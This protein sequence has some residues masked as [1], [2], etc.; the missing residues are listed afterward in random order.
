MMP[1]AYDAAAF[2][3]FEAAE[4]DRSAPSYEAFAA[5]LTARTI[6]ALLEVA[7]VG[8]GTRVLDAAT[9]TGAVA[10]E[11][12]ALGANAVG[13]DVSPAMLEL[14]RSRHPDLE[15]VEASVYELPFDDGA[16]DAAVCNFGLLHFGRPE[17]AV[18]ELARVLARGGSLA[19]TV[20]D[21]P[22]RNR[23]QGVFVEAVA[24]VGAAVPAG[25]PAAPS[26]FQFAELEAM[27]SLLRGAGLDRVEAR[28]LEFSQRIADVDEL[29]NGM[30]EGGVR[31]RAIIGGLPKAEIQQVR[32]GVERRLA[33]Y[34]ADDGIELP[35][36]VTLGVGKKP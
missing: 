19:L 6:P 1:E 29:W 20:W 2:D 8:S 24:E 13:V 3:A 10:A 33:V 18:A 17:D 30:L 32:E 4:W 22:E 5:R 7:R 34:R 12:Q 31:M 26:M 9:G 25:V 28:R 16:F 14:A 15:L 11:A 35:V 21:G 27:E 23:L 36:A